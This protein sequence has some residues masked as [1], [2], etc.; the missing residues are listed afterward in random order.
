MMSGSE[1]KLGWVGKTIAASE[2]KMLDP[3]AQGNGE[4]CMRGRNIMMGYI[5]REEKT[6][7]DIDSEGWLHSGDVGFIDYHG[8]IRISGNLNKFL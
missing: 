8:N 6:R 7:E 3:D 4:I 1:P 2:T 5:N